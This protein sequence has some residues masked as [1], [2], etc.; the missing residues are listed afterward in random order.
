MPH[1]PQGG[2]EVFRFQPQAQ[3]ASLHVSLYVT[4]CLG[5]PAS[6]W[7]HTAEPSASRDGLPGTGASVDPHGSLSE[8]AGQVRSSPAPHGLLR[9]LS[10]LS[11]MLQD[12]PY[13]WGG[14]M[15]L[16]PPG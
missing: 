2:R 9:V 6:H 16:A 10:A 12:L 15:G 4:P 5:A 3:R 11:T 1:A 7:E 13:I 8:V 14:L